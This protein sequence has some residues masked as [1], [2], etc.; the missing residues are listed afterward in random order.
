[1]RDER[2]EMGD[3]GKHRGKKRIGEMREWG[4]AK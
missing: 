4:H 1:M 2:W 3:D